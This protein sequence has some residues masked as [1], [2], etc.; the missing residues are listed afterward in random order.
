[1]PHQHNLRGI[2]FMLLGVSFLAGMDSVVK[3]LLLRDVSAIEIIAIRGWII[4]SV[5][6]ASLPFHGGWR[7]LAT[8]NVRLHLLRN[9]VGF[10]A[11]LC[12]FLSLKYLPIAEASEALCNAL[13]GELEAISPFEAVVHNSR[14]GKLKVERDADLLKSRRYLKLLSTFGIDF[15]PGSLGHELETNLDSAS[16]TLVPCEVVTDPIPLDQLDQLD[17]LVAALNQLGAEGT[18]DSLIYAFGLH[19]NASLPAADPATVLRYIQAFLLLHAWIVEQANTDRTRR[20]LTRYIDPFPQEYMELALDVGY[21][22][23][24]RQLV[25]DYMKF[26][27]TRNRGLDMLPIL[28]GLD[29]EAVRNGLNPDET[30]LVKPRPAF[31]YRLPDCKVNEP[32]WSVAA[33]WNRWVYIEILA[34]DPELLEELIEA[35]RE[36]NSTVSLARN[37]R[38]ILTLTS[39]LSQKFFTR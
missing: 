2:L 20:Y 4:M 18:Q 19:I 36:H 7:A 14:V 9:V 24:T 23:D 10:F 15:E 25:E 27:P 29:E 11:P 32:G 38:W 34:C 12:F 30:H 26:N 37:S 16:R 13:G 8:N 39:L 31:H 5:L 1:M 3:A 17:T 6:L 35:W 33:P 22:P 28:S 21:R